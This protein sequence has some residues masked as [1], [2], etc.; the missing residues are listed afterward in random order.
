M[1]DLFK[2][3]IPSVLHTKKSVV[4]AENEGDYVPFVVNKALSFQRDCVLFANEMNKL[5]NTDPL[6]QYYYLLNTIR[7]KKRPYVEWMKYKTNENQ[8]A[9]KEYFNYSN[10]KAKEALL[11]LSDDHIMEIKKKLNKGGLNDKS[12][13]TNRGDAIRAR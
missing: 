8:Q 10:D 11:V 12:R 7:A 5:P 9:V 4:S 6:M 13:R 2:E 3:V 1:S